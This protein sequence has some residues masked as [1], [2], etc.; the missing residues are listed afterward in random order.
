MYLIYLTETRRR[1]QKLSPYHF[2]VVLVGEVEHRLHDF[3][4]V[5]DFVVSRHV[6]GQD[7]SANK[8]IETLYE[9][10]NKMEIKEEEDFG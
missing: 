10:I 5:E 9:P 7:A 2:F 4:L 8:K 1:G 3:E 6:G